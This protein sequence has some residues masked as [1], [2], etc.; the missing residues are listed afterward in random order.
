MFL[1]KLFQILDELTVE[2]EF[3]K[4]TVW[5]NSHLFK[6]P[7]RSFGIIFDQIDPDNLDKRAKK[8]RVLK[9]KNNFLYV[10]EAAVYKLHL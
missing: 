4:N 6:I 10:K 7:H 3:P 8:E 5:T 9:K 2:Y 1:I